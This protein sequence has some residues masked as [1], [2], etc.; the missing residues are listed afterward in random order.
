MQKGNPSFGLPLLYQKKGLLINRLAGPDS[1]DINFPAAGNFINDTKTTDSKTPQ[2][3]KLFFQC[4]SCMW[5][6]QNCLKRRPDFL[7]EVGMQTPDKPGNL[8]RD[9]EFMNRRLH[10]ARNRFFYLNNSSSV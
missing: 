5:I 1:D 3:G 8:V 2:T 6:G 9:A 7:L 10:K 4:F